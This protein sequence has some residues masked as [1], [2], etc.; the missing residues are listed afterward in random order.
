MNKRFLVQSLLSVVAFLFLFGCAAKE[1]MEL[2]PFVAAQFDTGAYE[3]KVDNFTI[4]QKQRNIQGFCLLTY[5][6]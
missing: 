5:R 4:Y 1:P 2:P 6:F 3:S